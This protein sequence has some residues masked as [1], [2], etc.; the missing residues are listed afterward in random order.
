MENAD[1]IGKLN[2]LASRIDA[3]EGINNKYKELVKS[4]LASITEKIKN[5]LARQKKK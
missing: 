3:K 4:R 1:I 2:E 5:L